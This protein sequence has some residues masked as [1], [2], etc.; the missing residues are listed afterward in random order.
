MIKQSQSQG[1]TK[2]I[3]TFREI[4]SLLGLLLFV[5]A[6]LLAG[7]RLRYNWAEEIPAMDPEGFGA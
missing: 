2:Q 7:A 1:K 3:S 5:S 6:L 4:R